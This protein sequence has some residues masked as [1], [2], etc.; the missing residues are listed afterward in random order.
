MHDESAYGLWSL[1]ILNSAIFIFFAFSF[2]KPRTTSDWRGLGAFSAFIVALFTEMYGFPLSI[3]FLS[4]WLTKHYPD[5]DFFSHDNGH[6]LHTL[7]GFEGNPHW[8]PLH[9]VSNLL[10]VMGFILLS[11]AWSVL[12]KAQQT[13][14]LASTGW[15]ARCRHPQY[16]AF[17]LIMFGFLLQWPTLPTLV[18]FPIL[19]LMYV[20]LARHEEQLALAEFGDEYGAYM[21]QTPAWIPK[22]KL[23]S[24][25]KK[26]E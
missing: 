19:V 6:L 17:I 21:H 16:L 8:D 18:L 2:V 7:L 22:I 14:T 10:I 11:S 12:H 9:I 25:A 15:Y 5:V 3:Y 13:R 1:V 24:S 23:D 4:G 26:P 20:R